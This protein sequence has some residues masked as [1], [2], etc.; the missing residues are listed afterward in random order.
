MKRLIYLFILL[1]GLLSGQELYTFEND[2]LL[3]WI[4]TPEA[5]WEV[6]AEKPLLGHYS[7]HHAYDNP[8]PGID[9][10]GR[11]LENA[12]LSD[13]LSFS[14]RMRHGYNPSSGNNWQLFLLADESKN[15]DKK[16]FNSSILFGI[17]YY[18]SDDTIKIWQ[19]NKGEVIELCSS[20]LNY[21]ES[22]GSSKTP[23]FKLT[24]DPG[25]VWTI[26]AS[27]SGNADSL[28][29]VGRGEEQHKFRGKY[30]GFRYSYSSAQDRKL[31]IDQLEIDGHFFHDTISPEVVSVSV[32]GLNLLSV[33]FSES[34]RA[35]ASTAFICPR[36]DLD[37]S[38]F[39][40]NRIHFYFHEH[41]RNRRLEEIEIK[42]ISDLEGNLLTDT[43]LMFKQELA[44]FGDIVINEIMFDPAPSVYLPECEYLEIYNHYVE[45]IQLD[46]WNICVN[47]K[48]FCFENYLLEAEEYL[49]IVPSDPAC[50]DSKIHHME[51]FTS[52]FTLPNSGAE[53][54]L[55]D[56][57]GRLIHMVNYAHMDRY[58]MYKSEGG[59]SLEQVDPTNLCAGN[60]N[61]V[62]S[63]DSRGGTP[64]EQNSV[65]A[66]IQDN[67]PPELIYI[68]IPEEDIIELTFSEPIIIDNQGGKEFRLDQYP[69]DFASD[70]SYDI[71]S[72]VELKSSGSLKDDQLYRISL[73]NMEDCAGNIS[74]ESI[75]K[76]FK[77]PVFPHEYNPVLNELMY[78][79]LEGGNEYIE[80]YN[81]GEEYFDLLDLKLRYSGDGFNA[82]SSVFLSEESHLIGPGTYVVLCKYSDELKA[83]WDLPAGMDVHE[84]PDWKALPNK[85][86]CIE[87]LDRSEKRID[88]LFYNDSLHSDLLNFTNGVSLER[89]FPMPCRSENHC[90]TSAA[91]SADYGTPGTV[92]SQNSGEQSGEE[93]MRL[94]PEVFSPDMD[95]FEDVL[96][97]TLPE[98]LQ[99]SLVDIFITD[100]NGVM[101]RDLIYRGISG[102][103]D[104]FFWDG[105]DREGSIVLPGIYIIHLRIS[106][107]AGVC[108]QRKACALSYK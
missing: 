52:Q 80:L 1:P 38:I 76:I 19:L 68:G 79:P 85:G 62:A 95:G 48:N 75:Q 47:G 94:C 26:A 105:T 4:Q 73:G 78:D 101:I 104:S 21:Q 97:I 86:A 6:S 40:G 30:A 72:K 56:S 23:L 9:Y 18:C 83:E 44:E 46:G 34:V 74:G 2:S 50:Y 59:W 11:S 3:D 102:A 90:W 15:L 45:A 58:D 24:R 71:G 91:S 39:E 60:S 36:N 98:N 93:K 49:L 92:N 82:G 88:R 99:N 51:L 20:D 32:E 25:G 31:W 22:I 13:T 96:S 8:D 53:I 84:V 37:S 16:Y 5:R 42:G 35:S 64:G 67:E 57:F 70:F 69:L 100:L 14:F 33:E 65:L 12:E 66:E 7:L 89:I 54:R 108:V 61:W 41:F 17:N 77:V 27:V 106:N 87:I 107:E 10:I 103:A 81:P 63:I 28:R 29:I 43:L 55:S